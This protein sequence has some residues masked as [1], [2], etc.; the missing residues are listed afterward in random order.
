[1]NN[2]ASVPEEPVRLITPPPKDHRTTVNEI[3]ELDSDDD[4]PSDVQ[5]C[6]PYHKC[7]NSSKTPPCVLRKNA[8]EAEK[9]FKDLVELT[10]REKIYTPRV[11]ELIE[12]LEHSTSVIAKLEENIDILKK[13]SK[14]NESEIDVLREK[15][16]KT[17][18][19]VQLEALCIE[20]NTKLTDWE[21]TYDTLKKKAKTREEELLSRLEEFANV[22]KIVNT[23]EAQGIVQIKDTKD[24]SATAS[25]KI[26]DLKKE[27]DNGK[28]MNSANIPKSNM[29]SENT[30]DTKDVM[31]MACLECIK[32]DEQIESLEH[33]LSNTHTRLNRSY[34][35]SDSS[36]RYNKICTLQ[37]EL[38]AGREDCNELKEEVTTIKNQLESNNLSIS[39]A[40][41]LDESIG[42]TNAVDSVTNKSV[43]PKITEEHVTEIYNHDKLD[44][45]NYYIEKAGNERNFNR[46]VKIIDVM[47]ALYTNL[48]TEHENQIEIMANQLRDYED[49]KREIQE[50]IINVTKELE[51]NYC[52]A[53]E[54]ENKL[55]ILRKNIDVVIEH[56]STT[57]AIEL[58]KQKV[59][60]VL[61]TGFSMNSRSIFETI[62]DHTISKN[63]NDLDE[64]RIKYVQLEECSRKL[65]ME[66]ESA[67]KEILQFKSSLSDKEKECNLLV[68]QKAKIHEINNALTM[69]LVNRDKELSETIIELYKKLVDGNLLKTN[70]VD[71]TLAP[72]KKLHLLNDL[73]VNYN[74]A[75]ISEKEKEIN[76]LKQ[77][78]TNYK[79][80][81]EEKSRE[82]CAMTELY[83]NTKELNDRS[84][85]H[86]EDEIQKQKSLYND[87]NTI[88]NTKVEENNVN[89]SLIQKL[90]EEI[91]ILKESISRKDTAIHD[92]QV[93]LDKFVEKSAQSENK[94][95]E[96][97]QYISTAEAQLDSLKLVNHTLNVEKEAIAAEYEKL[98]AV[99]DQN[100]IEQEKMESDI[101]VLKE[102]VMENNNVVDGL[103][104]KI[105]TLSQENL[106]M[107]EQLQDKC[108]ELSRL[109]FNIK[110]HETTAK[111]QTKMISRLQKQK[112]EDANAINEKD[113]RLAELDRK[114]DA[115]QKDCARMNDCIADLRQELDTLEQLKHSLEEKV[116]QLESGH[117]GVHKSRLSMESV[118]DSSRRRR[119]SIHDSTRAFDDI[120]QDHNTAEMVPNGRPKVEE[121]MDVDEDS[122]CRSTPVRHSK[123][124]DSLLSKHE[125]S[126]E[127]DRAS[128]SSSATAARRRRRSTH[129]LQRTA[130][131]NTPDGHDLMRS[132]LRDESKCSTSNE[133]SVN[134]AVNELQDRL[135]CCQQEL[136]DLKERYKELDEECET[137]AEYLRERDEQCARLKKEKVTL[138]KIIMELNEKVQNNS[139]RNISRADFAHA[140]VNTDEDWANL[141]SV[142][143]DR[144][145][146]DAEVE[147][148]KR[149][150]RTIEELRFNKQ[151]LKIV[152]TK[153]QK[154][155]EEKTSKEAKE[156]ERTRLE[157]HSCREELEDV[158]RRNKE[159][160]EECETCAQYLRERDEQCRRLKET[161]AALEAKLQES[162]EGVG[163]VSLSMRKK[164]Q[165]LYD[166][167]RR[168]ANDQVDA[169][170][171]ISEDLLSRQVERDNGQSVADD[172]QTKLIKKL[173]AAIENLTEQK[174]TL[175]QQLMAT[176]TAPVYV[177][178]GSAIVQNQQLTDV[179]KENRKLKKM[180]AE[181]ITLCKKR[182]KAMIKSNRENQDPTEEI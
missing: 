46:D 166:L 124:R 168:P 104:C 115:L 40:M 136:E 144:M 146:F 102:S 107:K 179:M 56:A 150:T 48:M 125:E 13:L 120:A 100:K 38:E 30:K 53:K 60:M 17:E 91:C 106:Q 126:E 90:T 85:K 59:L 45:L 63:V 173:K 29:L 89:R 42:D 110:T 27:L 68:A 3:I 12:K 141:H 20:Y 39:Q 178:T 49:S 44:C 101:L 119:Q 134:S 51:K 112:D 176:A 171:E 43:M 86:K 105:T 66:L 54:I 153:M 2:L 155:L 14:E 169:S 32:K 24:I 149:L 81:I 77:D 26:D 121:L 142:V 16:I 47:K 140:A 167:N 147:K 93:K 64:T 52:D 175:E 57:D 25:D 174:A 160:D 31:P 164:R 157:L 36:S 69:D 172:M 35:D 128:R 7:F 37:N 131:R 15:I 163:H 1:M 133:C 82:L 129:D 22:K 73:L 148:N 79:M 4:I 161:M 139:S 177:A 80:A 111:I 28:K 84:L 122:S 135:S 156:L 5:T 116:T 109:E 33:K 92:Q 67:H 83:G 10:E 103:K 78:I 127:E 6:S 154:A 182:G 98:R 158:K 61:D 94:V 138:E 87:L 18:E 8:I 19:E 50:K 11:V 9:N 123:G 118:T 96:L 108:K 137:C 170:T 23:V 95:A 145:S 88:Y 65:K 132:K 72:I 74:N 143:V 71:D 151:E 180:N 152:V 130:L 55:S 76:V 41:D 21:V 34:S 159:L 58:F 99:I 165:T 162:Q 181:L 114:C 117:E 75:H 62:L 70:D 113:R 97:M